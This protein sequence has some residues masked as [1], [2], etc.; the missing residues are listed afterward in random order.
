ML[1]RG[2]SV[3]SPFLYGESAEQHVLVADSVLTDG[4]GDTSLPRAL[5]D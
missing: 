1:L 5:L 3:H 2:L 4:L